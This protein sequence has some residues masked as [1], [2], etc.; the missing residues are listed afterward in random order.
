MARFAVCYT[1]TSGYLFHTMVSALQARA[2]TDSAVRVYVVFFGDEGSV[3]VQR[4]GSICAA[5]GIEMLIAPASTL[6]G[7]HPVYSRLFLNLILPERVEEVLYLDGDTQVLD[8]IDDLLFAEPPE[9]GAIAVRDPMVFIREVHTGLRRKIND[10]W[11]SSGIPV[12][13]RNNYVNAGVLRLARRQ[14]GVLHSA[15]MNEFS[16]RLSGLRFHDQDACNL[17]LQGNVDIVSMSWNFP[18][19]LLDSQHVALAPPR[20]V[21]FMSNPRPWDIALRPWGE[22]YHTPYRQ[23][24]AKY[25]E[26]SQYWKRAGVRKK[27]KWILQQRVKSITERRKWQSGAAAVVV[28]SL[29][30]DTR[31]LGRIDR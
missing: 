5:R 30:R 24:A 12:D 17:L 29:E 15:V 22:T 16:D 3:E 10:A 11:D 13:L 31:H 25:P 14:I 26:I 9:G 19:F 4:F 1:A 21:H 18:G 20:I 23:F 8:N 28:K 27:G 7:L 6:N 2:H